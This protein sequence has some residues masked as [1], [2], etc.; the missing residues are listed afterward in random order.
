MGP[1]WLKRRDATSIAYRSLP[2]QLWIIGVGLY[3]NIINYYYFF[4][5]WAVLDSN[6]TGEFWSL[7]SAQ[8]NLFLPLAF[9]TILPLHF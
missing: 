9:W 8:I 2:A 6:A 5:S 7:L 3:Q 1:A 4:F